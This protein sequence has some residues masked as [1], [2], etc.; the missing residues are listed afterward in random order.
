MHDALLS[1][2]GSEMSVTVHIP[3]IFHHL[4]GGIKTIRTNSQNTG[5]CLRELLESF[6]SIKPRLMDEQGQLKKYVALY[7]NNNKIG[8]RLDFP[9][10]DEDEL[11]IYVVILGG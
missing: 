6:P 11:R 7:L 4:T 1:A 8:N 2:F 5:E 3:Y 10:G 9:V